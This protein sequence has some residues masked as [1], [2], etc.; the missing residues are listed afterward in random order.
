M[1]KLNQRHEK[2]PNNS[3]DYVSIGELWKVDTYGSECAA[4]SILLGVLGAIPISTPALPDTVAGRAVLRW[5]S[6]DFAF[7]RVRSRTVGI[8][9]GFPWCRA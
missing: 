5:F 4:R 3:P 7:S 9:L 6:A 1:G 2:I 8:I